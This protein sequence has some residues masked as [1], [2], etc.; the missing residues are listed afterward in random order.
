MQE[1]IQQISN[2]NFFVITGGP[3]S[4]KTTLLDGLEKQKFKVVPEIARQL[5]REQIDI[6]GNALPWANKELYAQ[7]MLD[8]SVDS[9]ITM[10]QT[11]K[12]ITFFDRGILDTLCYSKLIN[13]DLTEDMNFY[14]KKY[15]YNRKVFILPPWVDIYK[16]DNERKQTWD[17][18]V[19]TY[20]TMKETYR[21][22]D[23]EMVEVPKISIESRIQFVLYNIN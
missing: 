10:S 9:Y 3:G 6:G 15:R 20:A 8:R 16:I 11:K 7:I 5:I 21:Q 22:F 18:A 14:A 2:D 13:S 12:E 1:D 17:E 19:I 4:G 23:Y